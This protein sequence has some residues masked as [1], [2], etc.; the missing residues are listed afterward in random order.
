MVTSQKFKG[1][2]K[3]ATYSIHHFLKKELPA[4]NPL[5]NFP[6]DLNAHK[7][8]GVSKSSTFNIITNK[9]SS[10]DNNPPE[11]STSEQPFICKSS[12]SYSVFI[13]AYVNKSIPQNFTVSSIKIKCCLA[14]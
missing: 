4:N 2:K 8:H 1:S 6:D 3:S 11:L 5:A 13:S 12:N 14:S 10:L 7:S 9:F